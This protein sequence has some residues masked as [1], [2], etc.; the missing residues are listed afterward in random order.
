[1]SWDCGRESLKHRRLVNLT[2][3][4]ARQP[5]LWGKERVLIRFSENRKIC[6]GFSLSRKREYVNSQ[7]RKDRLLKELVPFNEANYFSLEGMRRG[8]EGIWGWTG[9]THLKLNVYSVDRLPLDIELQGIMIPGPLGS[10]SLKV[11]LPST[12]R[13]ELWL[14]G[15]QVVYRSPGKLP[16]TMSIW[17]WFWMEN[18]RVI[19]LWTYGL[20]LFSA[21]SNLQERMHDH[22]FQLLN[23]FLGNWVSPEL[24]FR[25]WFSYYCDARIHLMCWYSFIS[26]L[27]LISSIPVFQSVSQFSFVSPL[28]TVQL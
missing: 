21:A 7:P 4:F 14:R 6:K 28:V 8:P 24:L 5:S 19:K 10:K 27:M 18:A 15:D 17:L 13:L 9:S 3:Q 26:G 20:S 2:E 16:F 25:F 23:L 11:H 1:M 22:A 12:Q